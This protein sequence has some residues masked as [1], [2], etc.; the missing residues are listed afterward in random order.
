MSLGTNQRRMQFV[1]ECVQE[2]ESKGMTR[3]NI[4]GK[5]DYSKEDD[6]E[7]PLLKPLFEARG[8]KLIGP[9]TQPPYNLWDLEKC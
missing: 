1:A 3:A 7:I 5:G 4:I 8:W 2:W 6:Q 9:P